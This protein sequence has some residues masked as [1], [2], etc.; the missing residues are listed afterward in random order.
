MVGEIYETS[1]VGKVVKTKKTTP[2]QDK[3]WLQSME[4]RV[5][6]K[7]VYSVGRH[8]CRAF[9]QAEFDKAP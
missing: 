9:S 7:D 5:G 8:N 2:E 1:V 3:A 6:T 4:S